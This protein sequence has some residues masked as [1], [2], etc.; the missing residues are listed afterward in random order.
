MS[1]WNNYE[2]YLLFGH[3][4]MKVFYKVYNIYFI[5]KSESG[6]DLLVSF[7]D[8]NIK[9]CKDAIE[10]SGDL[11]QF[12]NYKSYHIVG[13]QAMFSGSWNN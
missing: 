12:S 9:L 3:V 7:W 11:D 13:S 1:N 10:K 2:N 4:V 5:T 8:K 6:C